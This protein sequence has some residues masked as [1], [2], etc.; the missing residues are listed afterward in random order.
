MY[1]NASGIGINDTS[2]T[3]KLQVSGDGFIYNSNS[4][5]NTTKYALLPALNVTTTGTETNQWANVSLYGSL[6]YSATTGTFT[7]RDNS[8]VSAFLGNVAK[9]GGG[10]VDGKMSSFSSGIGFSGAGNVTTFAGFRAYAPLQSYA[11]P[12]FSGTLTNYIGLLID[13]ING[14][15]DIGSQITNRYGIFQSGSLDRNYFAGSTTFASGITGSLLGTATTASYVLNAVSASNAATASYSQNLT[16][17]STLI[18]DQTLT[19]YATIASS[20]VGSNNL[21]TQ[22]TG[23]YTSAFFKYTVSN[24][25]S[26]R[27]GEVIAAWNGTTTEL[28][29][30]S[31]VDIGNTSAVTASI[32]ILSGQVQFNVQTNTSGWRIKSLATFM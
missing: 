10:N 23:S 29:D 7:P 9:S 32:S 17:G 11:L 6:G 25:G 4:T 18:V 12:A 2:A 22:N 20:I 26:T 27:A 15:T 21:F 24:G 5:L 16:V 13:D 3:H 1:E 31:T 19:D 28:T 14:T 30:F 8:Y